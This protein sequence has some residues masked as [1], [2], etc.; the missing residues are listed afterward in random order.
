MHLRI[1]DNDPFYYCNKHNKEDWFKVD[2]SAYA[3]KSWQSNEQILEMHEIYTDD[4]M[5]ISQIQA[6]PI[7][8]YFEIAFWGGNLDFSNDVSNDGIYCSRIGDHIF[9]A[10]LNE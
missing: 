2:H 4:F 1:E 5:E 3:L 8:G 7:S 10:K 6:T 9:L